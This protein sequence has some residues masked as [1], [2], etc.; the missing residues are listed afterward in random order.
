MGYPWP[1]FGSFVFTRS[2]SALW[3]TDIGWILSPSIA[4]TR[5]LGS[6][7]DH[8]VATAIGSRTRQFEVNLEPDRQAQLEALINTTAIFTDW[9]RPSPDSRRAFL[10]SVTPVDKF[11]HQDRNG[12]MKPARRFTVSLVSQ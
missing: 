3:G 4:Q 2:E 12:Q 7:V 5:P 8:I 1:S 11:F 10:A 9:E 6:N